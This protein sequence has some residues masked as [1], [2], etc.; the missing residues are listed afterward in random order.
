[1]SGSLEGRR[2]LVTGGTRGIGRGIVI[3][4]AE[5]GASVYFTGRDA[6]AGAAVAA[7]VPGATFIVG[8]LRDSAQVER[9]VADA[10]AQGGG[11]EFCVTTPVSI[12]RTRSTPCPMRR[13]MTYSIPTSP[14][15]WCSRAQR[16]R[17]CVLRAAVALC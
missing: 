12:P 11:L 3:G 10:I 16:C 4:L 2:A 17:H 7:E 13:G 6:Q 5:R 1:M 14:V 9:I 8:D 15:R